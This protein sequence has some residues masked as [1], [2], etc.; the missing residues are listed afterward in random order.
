[1]NYTIKT[2]VEV[3]DLINN[4][5]LIREVIDLTEYEA[6]IY[7]LNSGSCIVHP[8]ITYKVVLF[9]TVDDAVNFIEKNGIPIEYEG[10]KLLTDRK[11]IANF[12]FAVPYYLKFLSNELGIA[13]VPS[14]D[15]VNV[16]QVSELLSQ[17]LGNLDIDAR[18]DKFFVPLGIFIGECL[19]LSP[20]YK[21]VFDRRILINPYLQPEIERQNGKRVDIWVNVKYYL[22][23][24]PECD[25]SIIEQRIIDLNSKI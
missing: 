12:E 2:S 16:N 8:N 18:W 1:M 23:Y 13:V 3:H 10:S 7:V 6:K 22:N 19:I 17:K 20:H 4:K 21:W 5:Y 9:E 24:A 25:L 14:L 11:I 15:L